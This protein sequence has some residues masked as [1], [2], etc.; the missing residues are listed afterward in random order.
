MFLFTPAGCDRLS[1]RERFKCHANK[2]IL[3]KTLT[4]DAILVYERPELQII[5]TKRKL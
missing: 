4:I 1:T 2:I 3:F 5:S